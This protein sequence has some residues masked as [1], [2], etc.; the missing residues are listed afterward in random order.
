MN[1]DKLIARAKA[2]AFIPETSAFTSALILDELNTA[3][4]TQWAEALIKTNGEFF[5]EAVDLL[6][7]ASGHAI[8]PDDAL[9]STARVLTW[10]DPNGQES[11]PIR[12]VEQ[13]DIGSASGNGGVGSIQVQQPDGTFVTV[14]SSSR[15]YGAAPISFALTPNGAQLFNYSVGGHLRCR[16]S[17]RPGDLV[18]GTSTTVLQVAMVNAGINFTTTTPDG[19]VPTLGTWQN[20]A[21]DLTSGKS[22]YRRKVLTPLLVMAG[23]NL[24]TYTGA[25]VAV[26]DYLTFPGTTY[27]P[28]APLEWH[29]LLMYYAAAQL[30]SLRKDYDLETRRMGEA[31]VLFAKLLSAAQPRTKQNPKVLSA[32]AGRTVNSRGQT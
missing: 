3:I 6:P 9:T 10:V 22:P 11:S 5:T 1:A 2:R 19:V 29:D 21:L 8:F 28:N 18:A 31:N 12:R 7:D 14:T 13:G 16:Y 26:G 25:Q 32:W 27:V 20:Q 15:S 30:A 17:R 23:A 4:H 24:W